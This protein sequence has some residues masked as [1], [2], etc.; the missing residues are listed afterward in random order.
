[1]TLSLCQARY[2]LCD[3]LDYLVTQFKTYLLSVALEISWL[4]IALSRILLLFAHIK[5]S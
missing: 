4:S 3:V 2:L 5:F 1:M